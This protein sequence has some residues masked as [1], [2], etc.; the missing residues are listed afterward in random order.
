MN[1]FWMRVFL[2]GTAVLLLLFFSND[3]GLIDIQE[4]AIVIAVGVDKSQE[5]GKYD[6]TAQIAVP[7]STGSGTAGNVTVE[8][9]S[10]VGEAVTELNHKT[11]WYPTLVHCKLILLGMDVADENVFDPID[12]FL[13]SGT[14]E[15]TCLVA[16]C[17]KTAKETFQATSPV[18]DISSS[19]IAKVLSSEAQ[20]TGLVSVT[21]LKNFA[22]NYYSVSRSGFLPV[23][24]VKQEAE[25]QGSE[26]QQPVSYQRNEE[27]LAA[28]GPFLSRN[29]W[30]KP[31]R[32]PLPLAAETAAK[33]ESGQSGG[34]SSGGGEEKADVFDATKTLMLYEGKSVA[35]LTPDETLA[36]NMAGT[37]THYAFGSVTLEENEGPVTYD[38]KMR[39]N[40]KTQ[41][42]SFENGKPVF[43]F[44]IRASAKIVDSSKADSILNITKTDLVPDKVLRAA[45]VKFEEQLTSIIEK[46]AETD[47]DIF[48]MKQKLYRS[49]FKQYA[50]Y[51]DSILTDAV[52]RYD[53][54][55]SS[56]K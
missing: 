33:G 11:G 47:C 40:H 19:A 39:I 2:I 54:R 21:N 20:K 18:K 16:M 7:A 43:T 31:K 48:N 32:D 42:L 41:K 6:V 35:M 4:T 3:F 46:S 8:G 14:V 26:S 13:R 29:K 51:K 34:K 37:D 44:H 27:E 17:E 25:S 1:K 22:K 9:A 24:S 10:T 55:F 53:I 5:E 23:V 50:R 30:W 15:D 12:F 28:S 38:L 36:F 45:E 56:M 49:H 52:V